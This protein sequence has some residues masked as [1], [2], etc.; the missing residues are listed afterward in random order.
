MDAEQEIEQALQM[1]QLRRLFLR[2][3]DASPRWFALWAALSDQLSVGDTSLERLLQL[4]ATSLS[5]ESFSRQVD[6]VTRY[7]VAGRGLEELP[8]PRHE[9]PLCAEAERYHTLL[10]EELLSR[11]QAIDV[12]IA[13][14]PRAWVPRHSLASVAVRVLIVLQ[15]NGRKEPAPA[16]FR[17]HLVR[18]AGARLSWVPLPDSALHECEN[19]WLG[20]MECAR[21]V[22]MD[23]WVDPVVAVD[24][25]LAWD[26]FVPGHPVGVLSGDSAGAV[27]ALAALFLLRGSVEPERD[28]ESPSLRSSLSVLTPAFLARQGITAALDVEGRLQ[29]VGELSSKRKIVQAW[30]LA[31][32]AVES[33]LHIWGTG[34]PGPLPGEAADLV[35]HKHPDLSH[36]VHSLAS[37]AEQM[38]E[39]QR[40]LLSH[41]LQP[42]EQLGSVDVAVLQRVMD[43]PC[44]TLRHYLLRCWAEREQLAGGQVNQHFVRLRLRVEQMTSEARFSK[45]AERQSLDEVTY[46][47]KALGSHAVVLLGP[48]GAGKTTLLQSHVQNLARALLR[49]LGGQE[50]DG[51]F[52]ADGEVPVY[53]PLNTSW[54]SVDTDDDWARLEIELTRQRAPHELIELM[55]G[56]GPWHALGL[57]A[58]VMLDGLNEIDA[59]DDGVRAV[60]AAALV[61]VIRARLRDPLSLVLTIREHHLVELPQLAVQRVDVLEWDGQAIEEYVDRR[62]PKR[63]KEL[64]A[65]IGALRASPQAMELCCRPLHLAQ[66]CDLVAAGFT[67][68]PDNRAALYGAWIWMR[69]RRELGHE[70]TQRR[71]PDPELWAALLTTEARKIASS[72]E[73][74]VQGPRLGLP[75]GALFQCLREH[76]LALWRADSDQNSGT[77]RAEGT[78]R[79]VRRTELL[80]TA[81]DAAMRDHVVE[82]AVALGIARADATDWWFAHQ[83]IGEYLASCEALNGD[84]AV[85]GP[86]LAPRLRAPDLPGDD[87]ATELNLMLQ[88]GA[89]HW[90]RINDMN[91]WAK[92]SEPLTVAL[93]EVVDDVAPLESTSL[94]RDEPAKVRALRWLRR[95]RYLD[96][97]ISPLRLADEHFVVDLIVWGRSIGLDQLP[98]LPGKGNWMAA[99]HGWQRLAHDGRLFPKSILAAF[100]RRFREILIEQTG[101]VREAES[102]IT[103]LQ[104][105]PGRLEL[106]P[107]PSG[108]EVVGLAL[109]GLQDESLLRAWLQWIVVQGYWAVLSNVLPS[110]VRR[111]E[112][113]IDSA[114]AGHSRERTASL[115]PILQ[116]LRHVLLLQ[117]VDGGAPSLRQIQNS[118]LLKLLDR[119]PSEFS[120]AVVESHWRRL[121]AE[122]FRGQGVRLRRRL[123]AGAMLGQLGD[124]IRFAYVRHRFGEGWGLRPRSELWAGVGTPGKCRDFGIGSPAGYWFDDEHPQWTARL[125]YFLVCRL[126][127]TVGEWNCFVAARQSASCT[128]D[129]TELPDFNNP[130]QPVTGMSWQAA[131]DYANWANGLYEP[132]TDPCDRTLEVR[133]P[134]EVQWEAAVRGQSPLSWVWMPRRLREWIEQVRGV[135]ANMERPSLEINCSSS[136][137]MKPSP[138]GVFSRCSVPLALFDAMGNVWEWCSNG[139]SEEALM[140]PELRDESTQRRSARQL[141][142]HPIVKDGWAGGARLMAMQELPNA[143][144]RALK[145]GGC[146]A[147]PDQCR[148]SSRNCI[149]PNYH[150]LYF[151][152]GFRLIRS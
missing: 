128:T 83:S 141:R 42:A 118:G 21:R 67:V 5:N 26:I 115:D 125:G 50:P 98:G 61:S 29:P 149:S 57:R 53:L 70:F 34:E 56:G 121:L 73:V 4:C 46:E 82:A 52:M 28:A 8:E 143:K 54:V 100:W 95:N 119:Q 11:K 74:L 39:A 18:A 144:F 14:P 120:D 33:H 84:P 133:L 117:S 89:E 80:S 32:N 135:R 99:P 71:R 6:D 87:D 48:P 75:G 140:V 19:H 150:V 137:W 151:D 130:L 15:R 106:P 90:H 59:A 104:A 36:L 66:C 51:R 30:R 146:L 152:V 10:R 94:G 1:G 110:L 44:T 49:R 85:L 62:F 76:A 58:R 116:H 114:P 107:A 65:R 3:G 16:V 72:R 43:S 91:V 38:T 126:P 124:N 13:N 138:V 139:F 31:A 101:D 129:C 23:A 88:R 2:E 111:L 113:S 142:R 7:W 102:L 24:R 78:A 45:G 108:A 55:Q 109:I 127:V 96:A 47:A 79:R 93:H 25:A 9:A 123:L 41:L 86:I 122:A 63:D 105:E 92:L 64:Q 136:R 132:S 147:T 35:V 12:D 20:A 37:L 131:V 134:T 68:P 69:L 97:P 148:P 112:G 22:V 103:K 81:A 77:A 27:I 17:V 60:R 40:A 145:G